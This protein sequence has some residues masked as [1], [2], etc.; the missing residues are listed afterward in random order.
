MAVSNSSSTCATLVDLLRMRAEAQPDR[1]AFSFLVP[2][3]GE[4]VS[5]TYGELDHRARSI[6]ANLQQVAS[7]GD[8]VFL[9]LPTGLEYVAGYF[10]CLYAGLPAVPFYVPR[11]EQSWSSLDGILRAAEATAALTTRST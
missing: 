2:G 3:E 8:R 1:V 10:G 4:E 6:A 7:P 9:F 5:L 11:P